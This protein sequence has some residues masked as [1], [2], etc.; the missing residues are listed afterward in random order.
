MVCV[1]KIGIFLNNA[2][3]WNKKEDRLPKVQEKTIV[4]MAIH[5]APGVLA[6]RALGMAVHTAVL[7]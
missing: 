3:G 5:R 7:G 2:K 1:A 6:R 4:V